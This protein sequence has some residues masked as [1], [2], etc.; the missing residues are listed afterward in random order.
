VAD[1]LAH[2]LVVYAL[3]TVASWRV[4]ALT[5]R[6]VAVGMGGGAIPDLVKVSRL[7]SAR[8]VSEA[9][10]MP[11]SY[12]PLSALGGVLVVSGIITVTFA[13]PYWRRAYT[14]LVAGGVTSLVVDALRIFADG[15]SD[16]WLYPLT[17]WRP[18]SPNLYVTSDP[19]VLGVALVVAGLVAV[20]DRRV[21]RADGDA[22]AAGG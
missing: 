22:S 5:P 2:V 7:A 20:V 13:R 4:D 6:W 1:L 16:Q 17:W 21:V 14:V 8:T 19:R 9:T 3:L 12:E 15:R 11:F 18:P 10:G